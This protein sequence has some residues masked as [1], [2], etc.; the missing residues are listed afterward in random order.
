MVREKDQKIKRKIKVGFCDKTLWSRYLAVLGIISSL[1]TLLSFFATANDIGINIMYVAMP[2]LFGIIFLFLCMWFFANHMTHAELKINNTI[3]RV[4]EGNIWAQLDKN[5]KNRIGEISVIGV[6]DFYDVI[7]DDRIIASGSLH[8]QYIKKIE[9]AQKLDDLCHTIEND[10]IL[11]EPGNS[12]TVA[13][14]KI[15]RQIQYELGSVVEFESYILAAFTKFDAN[16]EAWL[17]AGE[18]VGFWM[19]FWANIDKIYA[20]RTINIPLM[21]AGITRFKNGKPTKQELLEIMLWTLKIS[22]FHNTYAGKGINFVIY[23]ADTGEI[24][25][26]RI[27]HNPNYK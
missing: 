21:G 13:S 10:T 16:N 18:Y 23:P 19:R 15:G 27:Q 20:G 7:V 8:G 24:N 6:N 12:T 1:I 17:T 11:N 2:F 25:F 22:G 26:Y 9:Q 3:V 14:R 5:P 4:T